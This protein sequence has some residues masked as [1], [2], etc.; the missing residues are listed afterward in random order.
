M[1]ELTAAQRRFLQALSESELASQYYLSGGTAL[2]AFYLHHR[3]S[4]DLDFFTPD[5][6]DSSAVLRL[7]SAVAEGPIVPRRHEGRLGLI[8]PIGSETVRVEFV[9]Y[10]HPP[11]EPPAPQ[12]G[13]LRVDGLRDILANKL[14]AIVDRAEAKDFVDVYFLIKRAGLSLEQG[15]EDTKRKFGWPALELLLQ[16]AFLKAERLTAWPEVE[17]PID[18]EE[19]RRAF[20]AWAKGLIRLE[21]E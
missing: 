10:D 5:A 11:I 15:I 2:S 4:E 19:L 6:V 1:N 8:V 13:S 16:S 3:R 7:A 14:S 18:V 9:R 12:L 20:R 21:D 17:P